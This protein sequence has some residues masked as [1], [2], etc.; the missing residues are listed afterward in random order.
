M[1]GL[2]AYIDIGIIAVLI[3]FFI[4]GLKKGFIDTVLGLIGG[5]VSLVAAI[6][7][8]DTVANIISP[9]FGIGDAINTSINGF[10]GKLLNPN[11]D[12]SSQFAVAIGSVENINELVKNAINTLGLPPAFTDNIST[13]IAAA[14]NSALSGSDA[15]ILAQKSIIEIL[16][17]IIGRVVLLV[18]AVILTFIAIRIVVALIESVAKGILR[19]SRILMNLDRIFGGLVGIAQG[20]LVVL[21][22]FTIGFFVLGGT[23]AN[24]EATD[25]KTQIRTNIDN[26]TIAKYVYE[27]N[28]VP[29]FITDNVNL[30][31]II[32]NLFGVGGNN[33]T[34]TP[35]PTPIAM[36]DPKLFTKT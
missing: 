25:L 11:N 13:S 14:I 2:F 8:A 18:I 1:I 16:T 10:L 27:S 34:P 31:N 17:P 32:K 28:P 36:I 22:V 29:K 26:S 12:S 3:I 20:A 21:I 5:L 15:A 19:T 24:P 7:L 23:V 33:E 4:S 6:L 30:D 35:T 9:L